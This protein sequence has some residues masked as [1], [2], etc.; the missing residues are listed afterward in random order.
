MKELTPDQKREEYRKDVEARRNWHRMMNYHYLMYR[1]ISVLNSQYTKD[2]L[3]SI[4]MQIHVPRTFMTIETIRPDLDRP[5]DIQVTRQNKKETKQ[6]ER[7]RHMLK[8]EW[9]RSNADKDAGKIKFD[10][11]LYGSGYGLTYFENTKKKVS[12]FMGYDDNGGQLFGD[13]KEIVPYEGMKLKWLDPYYFIPDRKAKTY[14][15][16]C[17]NSP[18][19]IWVPSIWDV[20]RFREYAKERGYANTDKIQPGGYMEEFDKVRKTIDII[21]TRTIENIRT[22]ANGVSIS[23]DQITMEQ[24]VESDNIFVVEEYSVD[25]YAVYSG[26]DWVEHV[27]S[28]SVY[29]DKRIPIFAIKDYDVSGELE[30]IGEAELIRWQ[31]Y[32]ENKVHN[33]MYLQV[34]LN[35]VKRYGIIEELLVDPT[36]ARMTNPLQPIRLKYMAGIKVNDAIQALNQ[37]SSNDVP[38]Q[39]LTEVKTIGQ[40]AT[41][42]TDYS[43][44]SS[45]TDAGT[46]GEA[47]MMNIAG[48]K[49]VKQKIQTMEES[50]FTP[51]LHFWKTAIPALYSEELDLL[52]NDG[53]NKDV[54]FLP[55]D[56]AKNTDSTLVAQKS[57][58]EGVTTD[59]RTLEDVYLKAGYGDV[60]FMSDLIGNF[61]ISIKTALAFLDRNNMIKQYEK[62]I[63]VAMQENNIN[64][65]MGKPPKWDI[66]KLTEEL[67]TQ[68]TDIIE[69]IDD[70][71]LDEQEQNELM[72]EMKQAMTMPA[73]MPAEMEGIGAPE[74]MQPEM[75]VV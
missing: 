66:S 75:P 13:E 10:A 54:K 39:F 67:L 52:L 62:A 7:V 33:L 53:T 65:S 57:V 26:D 47:E 36:Q 46:L 29:P 37:H 14:E 56:R 72:G 5:M 74:N 2:I 30:G 32:E 51:V 18:R 61:D 50:G 27:N 17:H 64:V 9:S 24:E 11:L 69:D 35:T 8:G 23:Q 25:G 49:R 34:L 4:G 21:Y 60:V 15:P 19:R 48:S 71:K 73:D 43:I 59:T 58:E 42:M 68:F 20:E 1:G 55:Y 3:E 6:A 70:Y 45:Q 38:L 12:Q 31:Q 41:G 16:D 40:M 22:K 63:Q 44:G 28:K